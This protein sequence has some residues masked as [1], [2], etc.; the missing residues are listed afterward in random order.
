VGTGAAG[1]ISNDGTITVTSTVTSTNSLS[2]SSSTL[3]YGAL[4]AYDGDIVIH[5]DTLVETQGRL[6]FGNISA[7]RTNTATAGDI[8]IGSLSNRVEVRYGGLEI[9]AG[10][11]STLFQT[12]NLRADGGNISAYLNLGDGALATLGTV[13]TTSGNVVIDVTHRNIAL[14]DNIPN[15]GGT[16][17]LPG[18][19]TI[20][21]VSAAGTVNLSLVSSAVT[22]PSTGLSI[23]TVAGT[24]VTITYNGSGTGASTLQGATAAGANMGAVTYS[25]VFTAN[26]T[27]SA[28]VILNNGFSAST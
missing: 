16:F 3:T 15:L 2:T 25:G 17:G 12:G 20:G 28:A 9:A 6:I 26:L 14:V 8:D 13:I 21:N 22:A 24:N 5:G 27:G 18:L 11:E 23:G 4:A 7:G 19:I 10:D 1:I